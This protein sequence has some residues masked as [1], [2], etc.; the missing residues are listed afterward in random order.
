MSLFRY[1]VLVI[2]LVAGAACGGSSGDPVPGPGGGSSNLVAGFTPDQ[3]SPGADTVAL[4]EGASTDDIVTVRVAVTDVGGI[5]G[6]AFDLTYDPG[7]A[8]FVNWTSGTLLEQ[9]GHTPSYQVDGRTP[10]QVVVGASR[11]GSAPA[12]D[13]VGTVPL[14]ELRFRVTQAGTSQ[15]AFQ[16]PDLLDDQLQPQPI[17]GIQWFG[18]TLVGN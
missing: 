8:S 13:A 2:V 1:S 3:P 5:F 14:I 11:Q 6:A 9:G 7:R 17:P 12:V 16:S 18:G 10:G 4:H 15:I